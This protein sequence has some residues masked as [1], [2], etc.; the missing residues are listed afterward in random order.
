MRILVTP[1]SMTRTPPQELPELRP[2]VERGWEIVSG[3][4]GQLPDED[5]LCRLVRGVDGW[6]AGVE[7]IGARVFEHADALRAIS[8]NGV[9]ADGVDA[10]AA[11][12]HGVQVLLARGANSRGVAELAVA[13]VLNALRGLS[14]ADAAMHDG[15][16][17]R[18]LGRE[19]PDLRIGVLG[20][21]AIGRIVAQTFAAMGADVVAHDPF[22]TVEGVRSVS[23]AEV[24]ADADVV[25]LHA[26][27]SSDG[28]P[29]VG[30]DQ[31]RVMRPGAV[32]V[33]TARAALVDQEAVLAALESGA[34]DTYAVDA[35]D[36]EPPLLTPL[37]RH[38]RT[39]MSPHL[40]GYTEASTRRASALAV[41]NLVASLEH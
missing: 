32:L 19:V 31:L 17:E 25:S 4:A 21:G 12:R 39:V 6:I 30:A 3:P 9:G 20:F 27:P 2:M 36:E 38:A 34:L 28:S 13:H 16:W 37:L 1:R 35:F 41:S 14:T 7:H 15:R 5:Q 23:A 11:E 29:V 10:A 40:G 33:N 8:R 26:P 22:A 18:R 24:F